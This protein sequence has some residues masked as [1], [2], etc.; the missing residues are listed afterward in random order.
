MSKQEKI[1]E[2]EKRFRESDDVVEKL[3]LQIEYKRI[4]PWLE[5]KGGDSK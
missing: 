2:L 5:D 1:M 3:R 4:I